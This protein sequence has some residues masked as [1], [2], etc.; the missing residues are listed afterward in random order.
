MQGA[1]VLIFTGGVLDVLLTASRGYLS[2]DRDW[3]NAGLNR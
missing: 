3:H 1:H 2:A